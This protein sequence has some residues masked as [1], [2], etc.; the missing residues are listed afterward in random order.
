MSG[1]MD[2]L[3]KNE[4]YIIHFSVIKKNYVLLILLKKCRKYW[5]VLRKIMHEN[6]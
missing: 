3:H 6:V 1:S 4:Q 5:I 2:K